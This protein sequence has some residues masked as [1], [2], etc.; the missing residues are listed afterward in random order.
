HPKEITLVR[1]RVS[2][3]LR[4][5]CRPAERLVAAPA[6]SSSIHR[7]LPLAGY[8]RGPEYG[9]RSPETSDECSRM[10]N[11]RKRWCSNRPKGNP[12]R[13][14]AEPRWVAASAGSH[15]FPIEQYCAAHR[16]PSANTR[17]IV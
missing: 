13:R 15:L 11:G 6:K 9:G 8:R 5:L 17:R 7:G 16:N 12:G 4:Y 3:S 14:D 2:P 10:G 1:R